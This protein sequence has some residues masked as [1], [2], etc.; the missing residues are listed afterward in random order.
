MSKIRQDDT[1]SLKYVPL[2]TLAQ[3]SRNTKKHD[4]PTIIK[5]FERHGFKDSLKYEPALNNGAGGIVEGNGR[6]Q[7]LKTMFNQN[8]NHPPRGIIQRGEDWMVPV[9][10]GVDSKSQAAAESYGIDHNL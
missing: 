6:D 3:W 7:A 1:L 10:F 9:L 8:K 2:K 4:L 5:S